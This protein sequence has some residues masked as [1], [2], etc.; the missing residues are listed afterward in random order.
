MVVW[1][2]GSSDDGKDSYA[3][4][5]F[6]EKY[7]SEIVD[8]IVVVSQEK[9]KVSS[10]AGMKQ[11]VQTNPLYK[12]RPESAESR[13]NAIIEVY[14]NK[15]F[16]V[17]AEHIMADSNEM[18]ALMLSTRPSIRYLNPVSYEIMDAIEALNA[19]QGKNVAAYTFDA[20]PNAQIIT[21]KE[22]Q[23]LVDGALKPILD[24]GKII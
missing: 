22:Y 19:A 24:S 12:S 11:T 18:H 10:R 13:L 7:W 3:E 15:D 2:K 23:G 17:L 4:Q 6:D 21:L 1:R 14:R 20:G 5:L 16:N 8:N 9:K